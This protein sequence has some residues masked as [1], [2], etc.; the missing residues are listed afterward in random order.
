MFRVISFS[1]TKGSLPYDRYS[2]SRITSDVGI[3]PT[4][5]PPPTPPLAAAAGKGFCWRYAFSIAGIVTK[6]RVLIGPEEGGRKENFGQAS[7]SGMFVSPLTP[8]TTALLHSDILWY[9]VALSVHI[10]CTL[11]NLQCTNYRTT[12]RLGLVS[13]TELQIKHKPQVPN[14][15]QQVKDLEPRL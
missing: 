4:T 8:V 12:P 15:Y 10:R 3:P 11:H 1:F 7:I 9:S 14:K 2:R 13:P 6:F 5:P